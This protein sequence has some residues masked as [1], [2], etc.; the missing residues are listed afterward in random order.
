[1]YA[2]DSQERYDAGRNLK[3]RG[4]NLWQPRMIDIFARNL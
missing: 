2:I 3:D 4:K 1:M